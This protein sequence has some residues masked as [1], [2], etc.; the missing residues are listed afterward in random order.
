VHPVQ[1]VEGITVE[2]R[3]DD[4]EQLDVAPAFVE[5][6]G[7]ER[8]VHIQADER[9]VRAPPDLVGQATQ[10]RFDLP[11]DKRGPSVVDFPPILYV[12]PEMVARREDRLF[13]GP[14]PPTRLSISF[15][16]ETSAA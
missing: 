12:L 10:Q 6:P 15:L 8:A 14:P 4:R 7:N 11:C 2:L 16:P 5:V 1:T 3:V 9:I 13:A